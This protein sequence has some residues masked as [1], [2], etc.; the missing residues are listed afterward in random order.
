[1]DTGLARNLRRPSSSDQLIAREETRQIVVGAVAVLVF[2]AVL[3]LTYAGVGL[4]AGTSSSYKV[5]AMFNRVDGLAI[6]DDVQVGGIPVG[7]VESM[8]LGPS[9]RARV[10][11]RIDGGVRLPEDTSISVQTDG[12]FGRK[13]VVV[14]PGGDEATLADGGVITYTQ[15]SLIVGELLDLIIAEGRMQRGAEGPEK[16][17]ATE[18]H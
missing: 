11:L 15:D 4:R 12:L 17:D 9:Y 14:E 13:F 8:M 6:G 10:G 3:V 18:S 16:M 5:Y 1:V 2:G 7:E